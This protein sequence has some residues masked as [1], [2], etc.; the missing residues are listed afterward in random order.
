MSG[1]SIS[2]SILSLVSIGLVST[3]E[4]KE[5]HPTV[6]ESVMNYDYEVYTGDADEQ[7]CS[8]HPLDV[9]AVWALY[10]TIAP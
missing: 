8:P 10:Q 5:S 2:K 1:A 9:M 7:D 6:R 3:P 4:Y